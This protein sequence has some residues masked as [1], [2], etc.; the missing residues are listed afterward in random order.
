MLTIQ[1]L[2]STTAVCGNFSVTS[3]KK[4]PVAP[5][6]RKLIDLGNVSP[7]APV[8]VMR[9]GKMAFNP[10]TL[11]AWA[12]HNVVDS[13]SRGLMRRCWSRFRGSEV[14]P[15]HDMPLEAHTA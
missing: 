4:D 6:C 11:G 12:E 10:S 9:D 13:D 8:V 2:G 5:L 15:S 7:D 1:L 3:S 14:R